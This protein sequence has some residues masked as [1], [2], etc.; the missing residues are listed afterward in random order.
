MTEKFITHVVGNRP[1]FM[2]LAPVDAALRDIGIRTEVL[3]TGQHFDESLSGQFLKEMEITVTATFAAA[4]GGHAQQTASMMAA[5]EKYWLGQPR[6]PSVVLVYG[7][8]NSTLASALTAAK[9]DI[10]VAHVEGGVRAGMMEAQMPEEKNRL[11]VDVLSNW[12]YTPTDLCSNNLR[13][14]GYA[15]DRIVQVGDVMFD[16]ALK[17][18]RAAK[19]PGISGKPYVLATV[20]R[21]ENTDN[22]DR[23]QSILD[24]LAGLADK[25]VVVLPLHPRTSNAMKS[26]PRFDRY[27]ERLHIIPPV[28]HL[29]MIALVKG[30]ELVLSDSGGLPREAAFLG[31]K[32]VLLRRQAVWDEL[33]DQG[34]SELAP[35]DAP[36]SI[37]RAAYKLLASGRPTTTLVGFGDGDASIKIAKH[38]HKMIGS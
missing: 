13:R 18:A 20:H 19:A 15:E 8:T 28:N 12:I 33:V 38:L 26:S 9:L 27:G 22:L 4:S 3:H 30:A 11:V 36:E 21:A 29:E 14:E 7:D 35:P 10:L 16:H 6:L 5:L 37:P 2:K 1:H 31:K 23:L 32:S 25:Y 34:F 17:Q 24:A